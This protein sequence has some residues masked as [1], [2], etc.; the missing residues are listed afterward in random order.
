[1]VLAAGASV[2]LPS[3]ED[4]LAFLKSAEGGKAVEQ[5]LIGSNKLETREAAGALFFET[6]RV[7]SAPNMW[8]TSCVSSKRRGARNRL[9]SCG[10]RI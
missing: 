9:S 3:N 1:M 5:P 10:I 8:P 6:Q 4:V 7:P 2:A